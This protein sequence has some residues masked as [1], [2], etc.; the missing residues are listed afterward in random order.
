MIEYL[1]EILAKEFDET[2]TN[3]FGRS[4]IYLFALDRTKK[5]SGDVSNCPARTGSVPINFI[6]KPLSVVE[7]TKRGL[8]TSA[9][10]AK[11]R[12]SF[13]FLSTKLKWLE[14]FLS[15]ICRNSIF[16][17]KKQLGKL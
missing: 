12:N 10:I 9:F 2:W 11:E 13:E 15:E 17:F 8:R 14:K 7:N 3:F 6:L 1:G 4:R 5:F 16:F